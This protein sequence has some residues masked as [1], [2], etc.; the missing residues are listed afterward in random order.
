[1]ARKMMK[2]PY[3]KELRSWHFGLGVKEAV[4]AVRNFDALVIAIEHTKP[5]QRLK[6]EL[7]NGEIDD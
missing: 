6:C 7:A 2:D 5:F 4:E 3:Y 1:M